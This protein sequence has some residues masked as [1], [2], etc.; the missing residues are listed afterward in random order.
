MIFRTHKLDQDAGRAQA[1]HGLS[2][3]G[4][5]VRHRFAFLK[6]ASFVGSGSSKN[7]VQCDLD[8]LLAQ[9][10]HRAAA[11]CGSAADWLYDIAVFCGSGRFPGISAHP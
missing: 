6:S 8:D 9:L 10:V 3:S 7:A 5:H 4:V 2:A 11:S 1:R